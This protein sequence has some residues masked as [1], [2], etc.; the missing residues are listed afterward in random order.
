MQRTNNALIISCP[1]HLGESTT[2]GDIGRRLE[3]IQGN[4][5]KGYR[6]K[7]GGIQDEGWKDT[8][9]MLEVYKMKVGRIQ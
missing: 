5:W 8:V 1:E 6:E 2:E 4:V 9:R 3:R 7:V